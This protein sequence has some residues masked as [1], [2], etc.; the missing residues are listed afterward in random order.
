MI[1]MANASV[2]LG[3]EENAIR[4][5]KNSLELNPKNKNAEQILETL[6]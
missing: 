4:A 2:K 5:Y 6:K 3:D 1:V